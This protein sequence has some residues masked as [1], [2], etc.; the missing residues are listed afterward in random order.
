MKHLRFQNIA[1]A[2][3]QT[4]K[5][6]LLS[7]SIA[8]HLIISTLNPNI[9]LIYAEVETKRAWFSGIWY[10]SFVTVNLYLALKWNKDEQL[11]WFNV[12]Y[13]FE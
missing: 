6:H 7:H 8:Q 3:T 12:F 1:L 10:G 4:N 13:C 9:V 5:R 11:K 2:N